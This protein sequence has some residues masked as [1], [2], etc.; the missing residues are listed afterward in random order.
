MAN[1]STNLDLLTPTMAS[2]EALLNALFDAASPA[3]TFGRR[4]SGCSGLTWAYWGGYFCPPGGASP[5]L[6]PN[7]AVTLVANATN[8]VCMNPATAAVTVNQSGFTA[9]LAPLYSVVVANGATT[10]SSWLDYRSYQPSA[11]GGAVASIA[12]EGATGVGV[13]DA[14]ASTGGAAKLKSLVQGG[15]IVLTPGATT[16]TISGTGGTVTSGS[17]EGA[18]A[19]VLDTAST[20]PT[21]TAKRLS[22]TGTMSVTDAGTEAVLSLTGA[23]LAV[24]QGGAGVVAATTVLRPTGRMIAASGGAG[25]ATLSV[26]SA[27]GA[28]DTVPSLASLTTVNPGSAT[29]SSAQQ[30]WGVQF[31][32]D[33]N[34]LT[35]L[36]KAT[37]AA[38]FKVAIRHQSVPLNASNSSSGV[39]LYDSV[40]G[41]WKVFAYV[42]VNP[43]SFYVQNWT[44]Y[45]SLSASVFNVQAAW[46]WVQM[47]IRDDNTNW[48][49]EISPDGSAWVTL[50]QE[51]RNTFLTPNNCGLVTRGTGTGGAATTATT[52]FSLYVG[53]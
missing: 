45:N 26:A 42:Y 7:G 11:I 20:S 28:T 24:Q 23:P 9:G 49:Y 1:S 5:V 12:N 35:G 16:I 10:P 36:V 4:A 18:G 52:L 33:G 2:K 53:T 37:V 14:S 25:T 27:L 6:V 8:Y 38:P 29:V 39:C 30:N 34:F 3:M 43:V 48:Y 31:S 50:Y 21:L 13:Y 15:V 17:N 44:T 47:R 46:E 40:S 51:A 22:G 32:A 41:K 19:P